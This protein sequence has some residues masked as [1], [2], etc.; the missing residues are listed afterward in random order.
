MFFSRSLSYAHSRDQ[1]A[2]IYKS[3]CSEALSLESIGLV[4]SRKAHAFAF[5]LKA[6]PSGRTLR[7][8]SG[9]VLLN[10]YIYIHIYTHTHICILFEQIELPAKLLDYFLWSNESNINDT[11]IDIF[12]CVCVCVCEC[13]CE[14]VCVCVCVSVCVSVCAYMFVCVFASVRVG[15]IVCVCAYMRVCVCVLGVCFC[16]WVYVCVWA[17]HLLQPPGL[18]NLFN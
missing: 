12:Y 1:S 14:C 15:L 3:G 2:T 11:Y 13:Y 5:S 10:S 16:V 8:A 6:T 9:F 4:N 7:N 18:S 17:V